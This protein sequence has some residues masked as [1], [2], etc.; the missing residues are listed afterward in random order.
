M[1]INMAA[2]DEGTILIEKQN[3]GVNAQSIQRLMSCLVFPCKLTEDRDDEDNSLERVA[4]AVKDMHLA[5]EPER[6]VE[7]SRE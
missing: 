7:Q 2:V 1:A 3:P 5:S 4:S 6:D